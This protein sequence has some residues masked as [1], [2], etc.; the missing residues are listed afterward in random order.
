MALVRVREKGNPQGP[1]IE[2]G[3]EWLE[4]WPDDFD[5]VPEDDTT[6]AAVPTD[7]SVQVQDAPPA[8]GEP[9]RRSF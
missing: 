4:R 3:E 2:V 9:R 7:A 5:L 8:D 6:P 1:V